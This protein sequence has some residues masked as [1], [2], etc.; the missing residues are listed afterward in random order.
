MIHPPV[1]ACSPRACLL[2][3][4][5][6]VVCASVCQ[7]SCVCQCAC[8]PVCVRMCAS[9]RVCASVR[10]CQFACVCGGC[11]FL[12]PPRVRRLP[13][14]LSASLCWLTVCLFILRQRPSHGTHRR[15]SLACTR[16]LPYYTLLPPSSPSP[17][18]ACTQFWFVDSG[19]AQRLTLVV[20]FGIAAGDVL[21]DIFQYVVRLPF[22]SD[23]LCWRCSHLVAL[24][25]FA[26]CLGLIPQASQEHRVSLSAWQGWGG[27][28]REG[29]GL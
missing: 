14:Y 1:S 26:P 4:A 24:V 22:S 6:C 9:L 19:L 3:M 2:D 13:L 11:S 12:Y 15:R 7:F 5:V 23:D 20:V 25:A 10:V 16:R 29:W 27:E 28:E 17:S 18:S 8:V 21:K